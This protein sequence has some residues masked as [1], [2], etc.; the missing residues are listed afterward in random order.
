VRAMFPWERVRQHIQVWADLGASEETLAIINEGV[1]PQMVSECPPYD[2]GSLNL[3]GEELGAWQELEQKYLRMGAFVRDDSIQWVNNCFLFP[4]A[5]GG[6][7]LIVDNRPFNEHNVEY[8]TDMDTLHTLSTVLRPGDLLSAFDLQDGYFHLAMHADY[9]KYFGFRVN[10]VGYRMVAAHFGWSG[11]PQAF[12]VFTRAIGAMLER[13]APLHEG[14]E[15]LRSHSIR[16]RILIDDFLLMFGSV[17]AAEAGVRYTRC[18]LAKLGVGVNEQKSSW[19]PERVKQHLGL[20]IDT[21]RCMFF[22]PPEKL[23]RIRDC[24]K[25][26]L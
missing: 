5:S 13:A 4:K 25:L 9:Q 20:T 18:L 6:Y 8:P 23:G 21:Q 26:L 17:E 3:E 24:A 11:S 22:V 16:H 1:V 10:G 14:G 2:M 19:P 15:V 7:R 12:M